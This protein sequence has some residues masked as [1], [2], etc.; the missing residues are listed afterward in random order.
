MT[1]LTALKTRYQQDAPAVQLGGIASNL[2]RIAWHAERTDAAGL[3]RLFRESK[4]FT[5]WAAACCPPDYQELLAELQL[6]LAIWERGW[7][8]RLDPVAIAQEAQDWSV[9]L[10]HISG[11]TQPNG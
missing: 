2:S 7:G 10:L 11:L 8:G 4:Y 3:A 5:E 9:R 1:D 6:Q